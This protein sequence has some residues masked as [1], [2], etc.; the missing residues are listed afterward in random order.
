KGDKLEVADRLARRL[1]RF[2]LVD[3]TRGEPPQWSNQEVRSDKL[4]LTV[5][6]INVTGVTFR[7]TGDF[8]LATHAD[9]AKAERGFGV[10]LV[11]TVHYDAT[12]KVIDR[13]DAVALGKHWGS[14]RL[15][16]NARPGRQ[17]LGVAFEL[18]RGDQPAD[19][20]PP[21]GSRSL[22]AYLEAERR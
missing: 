18:A 13:F 1:A 5:D 20:V 7:L 19:L 15:T 3:N 17:P 4:A 12:K 22:Q 6:E 11:G 14:T 8:L 10:A 9:V 21:Q 2:H 16:R